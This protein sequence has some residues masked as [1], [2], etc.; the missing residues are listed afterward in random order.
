MMQFAKLEDSPMFRQQIQNLE[1]GAELL[2]ERVLKFYKGCKKYSEG[3]REGREIDNQFANAIEA[4]GGSPIDN[5]SAAFGG[6]IMTKFTGA[7]REIS[8]YKD[9]LQS[10]VEQVLNERLFNFVN[11]DIHDVKEAR[12]RFDKASSLYDQAREKFLSLRK[13]T[14]M[15]VAAGFEEE[16][17]RA[18]SRF[19]QARFN[20]IG[21][22]Y[23]VETK[24]KYEF[25]DAVSGAVA[26]HLVYFKQGYELLLQ[27]EPLIEQIAA[28]TKQ[29]QENFTRE[30]AS[31]NERMQEYQRQVD[32]E[33]RPS[34]ENMVDSLR[35]G[36]CM[37]PSSR[38][39]HRLIQA[40]MQSSSIGKVQII[41]QGY[42][43]KRSSNLRGDWKRR[44]FVLDSRGMLYYY[45]KQWTRSPNAPPEYGSGIL[46]RWR[47]SHYH[48]VHDERTVARHTVDLLTSTIKIDADQTDLRFCFRIISPSKTYT[49]QAESAT[50]QMDWIEKITGVITS[51][52]SSQDHDTR[53]VNEE[54]FCFPTEALTP[55]SPFYF[56][57]PSSDENGVVACP[58]LYQKCRTI[59]SQSQNTNNEKPINILRKIPGNDICAD[60]GAADPEWASLNLGV[61]ICIECSGVH[62]NLG[63]HISKVRSLTLDVKVWE[64]SIMTLF[65]SLGNVYANSIWEELLNPK[66]AC[67]YDGMPIRSD[68]HKVYLINK[69]NHDDPISVKEKFIHAKYADKHFVRKLKEGHYLLLS[70]RVWESVRINDIKGVYRY[71]V[72]SEADINGIHGR[73][74]S[75]ESAEKL[76]SDPQ[77]ASHSQ[78]LLP[79]ERCGGYSLLHLACQCADIGMVELLLQY[80]AHVHIIDPYGQTPLHYSIIHRKAAVAKLLL[81]RGANSQATDKEGKTLL[82][83]ARETNFDDDKV[84][85]MLA[86]TCR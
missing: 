77:K 13:S 38:S 58:G 78:Q 62:R 14:R 34:H 5:I 83:I 61:L 30:K 67:Q 72:T 42:L 68:K 26:A 48:V 76:P 55:G 41:R 21:A 20:L 35:N 73:I 29:S 11:N 54:D 86:D 50:D 24:K 74:L 47:S 46:S 80:G 37:Q 3:I 25:L 39:S 12:K 15:D 9:G 64:P 32:Q 22:I 16:L 85:A 81:T 82:Q 59:Q 6:H 49:L 31:L 79:G 56:D 69:P 57:S 63:V 45:R 71:I 60:C 2:R 52:L 51:L 66:S 28:Y 65:G 23:N 4:F 44:Y 17:Y 70:A 18:R 19:E 36:D 27:M 75:C 53:V 33:S 7:L 1:E 43:S 8:V 40:V 10:Q 84:L